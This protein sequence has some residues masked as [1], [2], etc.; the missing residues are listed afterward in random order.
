MS[1][2]LRRPRKDK[3]VDI[4]AEYARLRAKDAQDV[5]DGLIDLLKTKKCKVQFYA[6]IGD[7]KIPLIELVN[8]GLLWEIE[9]E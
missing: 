5:F 2:G 8:F 3:V 6:Q 4:K 9:P 7:A 1:N